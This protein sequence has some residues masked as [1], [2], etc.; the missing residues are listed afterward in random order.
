MKFQK[1]LLIL[2]IFV[3]IIF[4]CTTFFLYFGIKYINFYSTSKPWTM[5]ATIEKISK[6]DKHINILSKRESDSALYEFSIKK[7]TQLIH[8]NKKA[9]IEDLKIGQKIVITAR[10]T[11]IIETIP[12][13]LDFVEKIEIL[14]DNA[15]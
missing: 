15:I 4:I 6:Y 12:A 8:N 11:T 13:V 14:D 10:D 9:H 3:L 1:A 7:H 2:I 5:T